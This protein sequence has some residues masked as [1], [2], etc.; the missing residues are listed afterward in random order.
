MAGEGGDRKGA[1]CL[2]G[3]RTRAGGAGREGGKRWWA[4]GNTNNNNNRV[5]VGK[6]CEG[7]KGRAVPIFCRRCLYG[8][9][10]EEGRGGEADG[11]QIVITIIIKFRG[12]NGVGGTG[13]ARSA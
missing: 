4:G 1:Q 11:Q 9:E 6:G 12:G 3:K 8:W 5:W 2:G 10:T 7:H 13:R